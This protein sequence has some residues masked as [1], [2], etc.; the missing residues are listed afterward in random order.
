MKKKTHSLLEQTRSRI[1]KFLFDSG[2]SKSTLAV[3]AGL[4]VNALR[5]IEYETWNPTFST[6]QKL[7]NVVDSNAA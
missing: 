1:T 6:V 7:L 2:M 4:S 5:D 3:K